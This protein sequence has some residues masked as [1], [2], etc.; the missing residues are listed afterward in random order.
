M[1]SHKEWLEEV[2][3]QINK[4]K[5]KFTESEIKKYKLD[6]LLRLSQQISEHSKNCVDCISFQAEILGI[7]DDVG[8]F[9][10]TMTEAKVPAEV[11]KNYFRV[12]NKV[13]KHLERKHRSIQKKKNSYIGA[14]IAIGVAIGI[15]ID[16]GI[17]IGIA[18]GAIARR[19]KNGKDE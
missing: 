10:K 14:G 1:E 17:G 9:S 18:L 2:T 12:I 3:F 7:I 5:E 8:Y 13:S 16:L 4:Y 15:V 11:K 19:Y 6:F